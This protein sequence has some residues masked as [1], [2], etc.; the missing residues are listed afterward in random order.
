MLERFAVSPEVGLYAITPERIDDTRLFDEC[1]AVLAGGCRWLQYRDKRSSPLQRRV[2]GE[3]LRALCC[4]H[5]A[6]FL[7]NDDVELAL[8]L[9]ADGVH[10][11]RTDAALGVARRRLGPQA[12]IG[13]SCYDD[14][15]LARAA[16]AAGASYVAFGAVFPSPT[17]PQ[18]VRAPLDLFARC[19]AEIGLPACAIGGIDRVRAPQLLA[20]GAD[21]LAVITDLFGGDVLLPPEEI[22]ARAATYQKLFED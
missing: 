10:L 13:A 9:G 7:V 16:R 21:L 14:L 18:A 12:L 3:A 2:R 6:R 20:A 8:A 11:G 5:G 4:N 1:A 17:K 22:T 19:R 15:E